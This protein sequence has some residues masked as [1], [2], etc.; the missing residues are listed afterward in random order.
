MQ[1]VEHLIG[2]SQS[3]DR[4]RQLSAR[5][6]AIGGDV[7]F[8]IAGRVNQAVP[9]GAELEELEE[10]PQV[11]DIPT[12]DS[13]V[14]RA[15]GDIEVTHERYG[16]GVGSHPCFAGY[17]RLS[18]PRCQIAEVRVQR[19]QVAI[20]GYQP[21]R[22]LFADA[23]HPRKV[24]GRIPPQRGVLGVLA[25]CHTGPVHDA[26]LVV[27]HVV[28]DPATVVEHLD[29]RVLDQLVRVPVPRNHDYVITVRSS[30]CS[31][32]G[33]NVIGLVTRRVDHRYAHGFDQLPHEAHL[34]A[35]DVRRFR[36]G[37]LVPANQLV[38]E[39]GF[40]PVESDCQPVRVVVLYE[41]HEHG[42]KA[43]HGVGDLPRCRRQVGRQGKEGAVGEGITIEQHQE[44]H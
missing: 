27:Q 6:G 35:Q 25:R 9:K 15:Q 7:P 5:G 4:H 8:S 37:R 29:V 40:G 1:T 34:L 2:A 44:C 33:Q 18:Q 36:P 19:V 28:R 11:S 14:C 32:S 16:H 31:Q 39:R 23:W 10:P 3:L 17:E 24:V 41:V 43:V 30:L 13:G 22:R 20:G 26:G 21:G 38:A 42:S 12:T